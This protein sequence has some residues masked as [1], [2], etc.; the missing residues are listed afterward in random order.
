MATYIT[1]FIFY[2]LAMIGILLIGFVIYKKVMANSTRENKGMIK[3]LDSM[4]IAPK[5]TLLVVQIKNE[6]FLIASGAEHTTFLSKLSDESSTVKISS[7]TIED[8]KQ[9]MQNS[10]PEVLQYQQLQQIRPAQ[11]VQEMKV[12]EIQPQIQ[13]KRQEIR[14]DD[15]SDMQARKLQKQ[16]NELYE[17]EEIETKR[18]QPQ[19]IENKAMQR[20]DIIRKLLKDM[21]ESN[22][23]G[24]KF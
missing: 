6:K 3:I 4:S 9:Q 13:P 20:R 7:K 15:V 10:N 19:P 12:Q 17:Q 8:V 24:S 23:V 22:K 21:N 11:Q 1:A 18:Q 14:F 16:F 5:K 2:T